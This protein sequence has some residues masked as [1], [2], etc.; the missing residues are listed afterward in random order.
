MVNDVVGLATEK[1]GTPLLIPMVKAGKFVYQL[2]T[3]DQIKA[4]TTSQIKTLPEK[5]KRVEHVAPYRV[6][7]S[8]K[9]NEL[10]AQ[11]KRQHLAHLKQ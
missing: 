7:F 6:S 11:A 4:Y 3:L 10:L 1:L 9:L 2:P 8:K 5:L